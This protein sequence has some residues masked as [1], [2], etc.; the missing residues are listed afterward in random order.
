[1]SWG[2]IQRSEVDIIVTNGTF[3]TCDDDINDQ[4]TSALA[5]N[6]GRI[7]DIGS[8]EY[9]DRQYCAK[10]SID[11]QKA[12][13]HPGFIE[14]HLHMTSTAFHG[15]RIDALSTSG[16]GYADLKCATDEE[17]TAA[18][19][20]GLSIA[21]LRKG[22]TCFVEPGTVFETDALANGVTDC[23]IRAL[24]SAPYA[25]DCVDALQVAA[26]GLVSPKIVARAP[27]D[28]QRVMDQNAR[29]LRRNSDP[30]ALVRGFVCL[31]GEGSASNELTLAAKSLARSEGVLFNQHQG[32]IPDTAN[33]EL[34]RYGITG[35]ARLEKLGVLDEA[36]TLTHLNVVSRDDV[37]TILDSE[38]G[39][40]WC[41]LNS[42]QRS[43][44]VADPCNHP[45]LYRQGAAVGI[46]VDTTLAYPLGS[47]GIAAK[48]LSGAINDPVSG[49]DI[50]DMQTLSAAR[51]IG[52][53]HEL[54][55]LSVGKRADIVIRS[56]GDATQSPVD[57]PGELLGASSST[58]PVETV[59]VAGRIVMQHGQVTT[60]DQI[61]VCEEVHKQRKKLLRRAGF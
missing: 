45:S 49:T 27:A 48:L 44:F 46:G 39:I 32:Y 11:A 28:A 47:G 54:G 31:Y 52:I 33:A 19:A 34:R 57:D 25:W 8:D 18:F 1:M 43:L 10:T 17:A 16:P 21:L 35:V 40:I 5:V 30:D 61:Q 2:E 42:L 12:I 53:D 56:Q 51:S 29:E 7:I 4:S 58:L 23:G 59:I 3:H 14:P 24:I 38:T 20:M 9:I 15:F 60:L 41:P 55:S 36:T 50:V 26:P 22:F 6:E 37:N 13:V